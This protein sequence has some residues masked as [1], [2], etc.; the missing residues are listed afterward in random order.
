MLVHQNQ[1]FFGASLVP[2][3]KSYLHSIDA[4][5]GK[6]N[7]KGFKKEFHDLTFQGAML[8]NGE[9]STY[10]RAEPCHSSSQ[11]A[12]ENDSAKSHKLVELSPY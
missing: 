5:S 12:M 2:W 1:A 6:P 4:E 3:E 11:Q 8:T 10:L 9:R 7:A